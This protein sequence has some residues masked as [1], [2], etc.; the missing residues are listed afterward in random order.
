MRALG[1]K[2][3]R[4]EHQRLVLDLSK[5]I[6][7]FLNLDGHAVVVSH[8]PEIAIHRLNQTGAK[9]QRRSAVNTLRYECVITALSVVPHCAWL[10]V[11]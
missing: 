7:S 1:Q 8:R 5:L 11:M 6:H 2:D 9:P 3:T 4:P 10:S